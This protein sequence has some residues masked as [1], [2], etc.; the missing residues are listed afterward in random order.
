MPQEVQSAFEALPRFGPGSLTVIGGPG[1]DAAHPYFV[2]FDGQALA[3]QD[4]EQLTAEG[5]ALTEALGHQ[6]AYVSTALPGGN[7]T[8]EIAVY[9]SN[10]GGLASSGTIRVEVG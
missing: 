5:S 1:A 4:V 7:G 3:N 2:T 9:P 6:S 10:V 8:V